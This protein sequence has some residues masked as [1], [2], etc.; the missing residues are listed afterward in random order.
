MV[1]CA[2]LQVWE[3][4]EYSLHTDG[5]ESEVGEEL[6]IV[7]GGGGCVFCYRKGV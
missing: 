2:V 6:N 5:E 1:G 7:S 3:G 4:E